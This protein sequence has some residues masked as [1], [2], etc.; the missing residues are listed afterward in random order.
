MR[1]FQIEVIAW[2]HTGGA[3]RYYF[4]YERAPEFGSQEFSKRPD[5]IGQQPCQGFG[6]ATWAGSVLR[7]VAPDQTEVPS[8][9]AV[10]RSC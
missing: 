1:G 8:S 2:N 6:G 9:Y 3:I 10:G 4:D 7:R 5:M